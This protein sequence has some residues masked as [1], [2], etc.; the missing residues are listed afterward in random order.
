M[1]AGPVLEDE[2]VKDDPLWLA[3]RGSIYCN[4]LP[5]LDQ[6]DKVLPRGWVTLTLTESMDCSVECSSWKLLHGESSREAREFNELPRT[7]W[8]EAIV[9]C[10]RTHNVDDGA[11]FVGFTNELPSFT[12]LCAAENVAH[13]ELAPVPL[14]ENSSP[15]SNPSS[16]SMMGSLGTT[17]SGG[18]AARGA[19]GRGDGDGLFGV[20]CG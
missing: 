4:D 17:S 12:T 10:L 11:G 5:V 9:A 1:H 19:A 8:S 7:Q 16:S 6:L 18:R 14:S 2:L 20:E 15:G 3:Y 13:R